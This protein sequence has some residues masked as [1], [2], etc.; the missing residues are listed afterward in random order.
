MRLNPNLTVT[1][2]LRTSTE[3]MKVNLISIGQQ[4]ANLTELIKDTALRRKPNIRTRSSSFQL[5][6]AGTSSE[7]DVL[8]FARILVVDTFLARFLQES[9]NKSIIWRSLARI[10]FFVN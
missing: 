5:S 7:I 6:T 1:H 10:Y 2:E 3:V 9:C 8:V 4:L